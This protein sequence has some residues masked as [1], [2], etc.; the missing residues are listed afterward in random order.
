MKRPC[1]SSSSTSRT[2]G[3]YNRQRNEHEPGS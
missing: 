2:F 1:L 3:G